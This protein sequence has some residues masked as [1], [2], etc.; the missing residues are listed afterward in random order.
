MRHLPN[1]LSLIRLLT[2]PLLPILTSESPTAGFLLLLALALTDAL[3][4]L[5]AR[6][7]GWESKAGKFLDPLADKLFLFF[8]LLSVFFVLDV[9]ISPHLFYLLVVRDASLIVGSYLLKAK[10]FVPEPTFTGKLATFSTIMVV[11]LAYIRAAWNVELLPVFLNAFYLLA[12]VSVIISWIQY[13]TG[14]V[15][16]LRRDEG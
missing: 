3:D 10:G 13:A 8:G 1:L 14:A 6:R 2:S 4:G 7:F 9:E 5:L 15:R 16:F 12:V 11:L